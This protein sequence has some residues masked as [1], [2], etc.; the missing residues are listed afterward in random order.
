[1]NLLAKPRGRARWI[2][3]AGLAS[4]VAA[5][6]PTG[7]ETFCPAVSDAEFALLLQPAARERARAMVARRCIWFMRIGDAAGRFI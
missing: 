1:M 2:V 3:G 4:V 7:A 6:A 5:F